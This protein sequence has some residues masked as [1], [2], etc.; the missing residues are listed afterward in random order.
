VGILDDRNIVTVL[1]RIRID[2]S[3]TLHSWTLTFKLIEF[4]FQFWDRQ[5]I[6]CECF[7]DQISFCFVWK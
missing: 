3:S 1:K 4:W 5:T 6:L 2:L 7:L